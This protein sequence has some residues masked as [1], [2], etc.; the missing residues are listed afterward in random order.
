MLSK[1]QHLIMLYYSNKVP[2]IMAPLTEL[3]YEKEI[4]L[5]QIITSKNHNSKSED[6]F[7]SNVFSVLGCMSY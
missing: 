1:Y 3:C 5:R 4:N 6:C 2:A 7:C